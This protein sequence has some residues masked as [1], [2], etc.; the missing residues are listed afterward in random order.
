MFQYKYSALMLA[1][2][3]SISAPVS[4]S[5]DTT[6]SPYV[7]GG[8]DVDTNTPAS[9]NFMASLRNNKD[10]ETPFC[11]ATI[12]NDQWVLT[13][14]HC[15]VTGSGESAIVMAPSDITITAGLID[16]SYP[17]K[18]H[19]FSAT[20]VVVHP[21]YSPVAIVEKDSAK[22]EIISTALDN[23]VA[24]IR[25]GRKFIDLGNVSLPTLSATIE[26]EERLAEEWESANDPQPS[27]RPV[28]IKVFGWGATEPS[29]TSSGTLNILQ[30]AELSSFPIDLC[31]ERL[32][33]SDNPGLIID[34]PA[35]VTKLCTLP[36]KITGYINNTPYGADACFGDS[37]GPIFAKNN[38]DEWLQVGIVSG[39]TVGNPA[40]GSMTRPGFYARVGYYTDWI[41]DN[42]S[43]KPMHPITPPDFL[44]DKYNDQDGNGCNDSISANN[45]NIGKDRD[46]GGSLGFIGLLLLCSAAFYRRLRD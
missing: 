22:T 13:A 24:L 37:G 17:E 43:K 25:V 31:H 42:S 7:V 10:G 32:E 6:V 11:G 45:C 15:V 12:I 2:I 36:P 8:H 33:S 27:N 35:N 41:I 40:C 9:E 21:D 28:N 19:L 5:S 20:H 44:D 3:T 38:N 30:R 34:S 29:G 26:I 18:T 46:S 1:I 16:N 4:A 39:G 23:D 14:A